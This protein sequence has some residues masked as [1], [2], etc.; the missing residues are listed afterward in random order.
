[1]CQSESSRG[2]SPR[3]AA[4]E[5]EGEAVVVDVGEDGDEVVVDPGAVLVGVSGLQALRDQCESMLP[6]CLAQLFVPAGEVAGRE[7]G[8]AP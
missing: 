5:V 3:L 6:G 8:G 7:G 4:D 2:C 1:M